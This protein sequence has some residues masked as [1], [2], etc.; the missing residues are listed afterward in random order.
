MLLELAQAE[1]K[2]YTI[3]FGRNCRNDIIEV[4]GVNAR[5]GPAGPHSL[6]GRKGCGLQQRKDIGISLLAYNVDS[7]LKIIEDIYLN[8][9]MNTKDAHEGLQAFLDKRKPE[10]KNE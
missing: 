10:W 9:L 5:H 1:V 4:C 7:S 3:R 2:K 8:E 6:I